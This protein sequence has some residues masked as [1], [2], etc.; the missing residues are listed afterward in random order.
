MSPSPE[1]NDRSIVKGPGRGTDPLAV[2]GDAFGDPTRR[3]LYRRVV[4]SEEPLSAGELAAA[5]GL[6]RTVV[7]SH[8]EK[9][10]ELG[11]LDSAPRRDGRGG[12]PAKLYLPGSPD[13][14]VSI[15]ERRYRRF[16]LAL[17]SVLPQVVE[18]R[19]L[20]RVVQDAGRDAGIAAGAGSF[21]EAVAW[22]NANGYRAGLSEEEGTAVL[23]MGNCIA[24]DLAA[25]SPDIIC[26]YDRA[27]VS[28]LFDLPPGSV[29]P[30]SS[31]AAG[32]PVCRLALRP[33]G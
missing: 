26:G 7:R 11:L 1:G 13:V 16:A 25:V 31:I 21:R 28:A 6:H 18:Q 14:Q 9:L 33:P 23:E 4:I 15:P 22:L 5:T 3:D 30:L 27:L 19:D 24:G 10:V 29:E 17:L 8:L 20:L 2:L 32:D 12:R